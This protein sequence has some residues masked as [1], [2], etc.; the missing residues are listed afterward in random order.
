MS[1]LNI[2][3]IPI[4]LKLHG[5]DAKPRPL[6]SQQVIIGNKTLAGQQQKYPFKHS[7]TF[8]LNPSSYNFSQTNT[9][10]V[11][12]KHGSPPT[13]VIMIDELLVPPDKSLVVI[14]IVIL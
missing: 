8:T 2:T 13:R 14:W 5:S 10:F 7:L 9:V 6:N 12:F 4:G 11:L 1:R 3:C